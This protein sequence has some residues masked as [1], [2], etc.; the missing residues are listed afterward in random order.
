MNMEFQARPCRTRPLSPLELLLV[1]DLNWALM[2]ETPKQTLQKKS[3][4]KKIHYQKHK[5]GEI[6][7]GGLFEYVSN[8]CEDVVLNIVITF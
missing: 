6:Y 7:I 3:Q 5:V 8:G 4:K 1:R 2:T